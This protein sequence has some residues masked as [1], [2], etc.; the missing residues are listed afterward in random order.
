MTKIAKTRYQQ[1]QERLARWQGRSRRKAAQA[2][3]EEAALSH[4]QLEAF[5]RETRLQ[6]LEEKKKNTKIA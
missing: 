2:A 6:R 3:A 4:V 5:M 1:L